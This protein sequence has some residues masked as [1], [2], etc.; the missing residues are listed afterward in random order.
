MIN[1][2]LL[3]TGFRNCRGVRLL[4]VPDRHYCQKD[5]IYHS[6]MYKDIGK[7]ST[8]DS[9][10]MINLSHDAQSIH[11]PKTDNM[12]FPEFYFEND[13][14]DASH[15]IHGTINLSSSMHANLPQ[16]PNEAMAEHERP[17]DSIM[18]LG[19][20]FLR[21]DKFISEEL[22]SIH[23]PDGITS[24][25]DLVSE[26][27]KLAQYCSNEERFGIT[28][29]S[30]ASELISQGLLN[31]D[32]ALDY[33][34]KAMKDV[35]Q[36]W[37]D[38]QGVSLPNGSYR[39]LFYPFPQSSKFNVESFVQLYGLLNIE[40][41]ANDISLLKRGEVSYAVV[42]DRA[43]AAIREIVKEYLHGTHSSVVH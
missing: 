22:V 15:N 32:I 20:G 11:M 8:Q 7:Q 28:F 2:K 13:T 43:D 10:E 33:Q 3:K 17:Y 23:E 21:N 36:F 19:E 37:I 26:E 18:S 14:I 24:S 12:E 39:K 29:S 4:Q 41:K 42:A 27:A 30:G 9:S 6:N 25:L 34:K 5:S 16:P 38:S 31:V 40:G 1:L 35:Y